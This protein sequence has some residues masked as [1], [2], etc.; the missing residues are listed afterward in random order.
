MSVVK[1][2]LTAGAILLLLPAIGF[3][4]DQGQSKDLFYGTF[5]NDQSSF[6]KSVHE[7]GVVK[8]Y[9]S[10]SD[11][12]PFEQGTAQ[13]I[14]SWQDSNGNFWYKTQVTMNGKKYQLLQ[15]I[16]KVG[17][18]LQFVARAVAEFDSENFP[19]KIDATDP[20]Y[21]FYYRQKE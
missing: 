9:K 20:T 10:I 3:T 16:N 8:D 11:T 2:F 12:V 14:D 18:V 21:S 5:T 19:T 6:Q 17:T 15:K 7:P 13:N 1:W 4:Q